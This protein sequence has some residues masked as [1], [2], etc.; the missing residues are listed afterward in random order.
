MAKHD[1][2]LKEGDILKGRYQIID[3]IGSGGMSAVYLAK[4]LGRENQFWA[5]KVADMNRKIS[6]RLFSEAKLLSELNHP[7]LPQIADFFSSEDERYFYLV[8]EYVNG[9]SLYQ[10]FE[11][12]ESRMSEE[13]VIDFCL[14]LCDVLIYLHS[15]APAIIY[16]DIKPANIMMTTQGEL[17]LIDFGIARKYVSEKAKDTLQIGTVGFAAPEQFEKKAV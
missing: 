15:R 5:V 4:E 7:S 13:E 3:L 1:I 9:Q 8:Q 12:K 10:I 2:Q 16:R 14:P 6:R 17:K 11:Q